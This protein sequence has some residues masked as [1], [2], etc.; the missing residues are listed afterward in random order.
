M[1]RL[2]NDSLREGVFNRDRIAT[3]RL[4]H[5]ACCIETELTNCGPTSGAQ[6]DVPGVGTTIN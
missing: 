6:I 4:T 5:V 3:G 2:E 1:S